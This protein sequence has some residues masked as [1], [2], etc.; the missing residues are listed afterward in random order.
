[1]VAK[2]DSNELIELCGQ[3]RD[4]EITADEIAR[5]EQILLADAHALDFYRRFMA[6][7]SGLEQTV[8]MEP[9]SDWNV[10]TESEQ[11]TDQFRW[12]D[13][14]THEEAATVLTQHTAISAT[15][16]RHFRIAAA[17]AAIVSV[18]AVILLALIRLDQN[19]PATGYASLMQAHQAV[20]VGGRRLV[21]GDRVKSG[22]YSLVSGAVLLEFDT[23]ARLLIQAPAVFSADSEKQATLSSGVASLTVPPAATGFQLDTPIGQIIDLGTRIG[24]IMDAEDGLDVHVFEG[25]AEVRLHGMDHQQ[26]LLAGEAVNFEAEN[27]APTQT[28]SEQAYFA[29]NIAQLARLPTVSGDI[30]LRVSPPKAVRR[31]QSELV[32]I[33]R[34]TVFQEAAG[35]TVPESVT[36]TLTGPGEPR[37]LEARDMPV[38]V[39]TRV[40]SFLV[41]FAVPRKLRRTDEKLMAS[42]TI[43]FD[44]PVVGISSADMVKLR[45]LFGHA[46]TEYP[47]DKRT[48]LENSA[49]KNRDDADWLRLS[50]D[51]RTVEFRLTIHG[52][53]AAAEEDFVDQLRI[54]VESE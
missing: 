11:P 27:L 23:G 1:M 47:R 42:G 53:E 33:G 54:L 9:P 22:Q 52:R 20:W 26:Q 49:G 45:D 51:R 39:G 32:D 21:S 14:L 17:V 8:A 41:H 50:E 13:Q 25:S 19:P 28:S 46:A 15:H 30:E 2:A 40:D 36:V 6:M 29:Q 12:I 10:P 43:M 7:C 24:V 44:R 18:S 34:A 16:R 4:E 48:G 31:I 35:V 38:P 3:V 5:L 37:S